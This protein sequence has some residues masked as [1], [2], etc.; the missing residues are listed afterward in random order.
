[1]CR[2]QKNRF[3]IWQEIEVSRLGMSRH[4]TY[5]SADLRTRQKVEHG[6]RTVEKLRTP[7]VLPLKYF[8]L[9]L[10]LLPHHQGHHLP[11]RARLSPRVFTAEAHGRGKGS[12]QV[13]AGLNPQRHL[14]DLYHGCWKWYSHAWGSQA[15]TAG[16]LSCLQR[17]TRI[18]ASS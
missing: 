12:E 13:S 15:G 14:R 5:R 17:E 16:S 1:M 18:A 9:R 4:L 11:F 6:G 2:V 10:R 3:P 7:Q 8:T